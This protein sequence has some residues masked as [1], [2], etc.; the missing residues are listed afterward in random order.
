MKQKSNDFLFSAMAGW[1]VMNLDILARLVFSL[2]LNQEMD[3]V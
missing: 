2:I 1:K 3:P